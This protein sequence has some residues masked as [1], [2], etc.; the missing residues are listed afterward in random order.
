VRWS[1][2]WDVAGF[3]GQFPKWFLEEM[4]TRSASEFSD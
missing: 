2:F 1:D 3:V 4:A